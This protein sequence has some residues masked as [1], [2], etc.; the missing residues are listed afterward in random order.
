[1]QKTK[2][3]RSKS[4]TFL[5]RV[6]HRVIKRR[7]SKQVPWYL[8]ATCVGNRHKIYAT[9]NLPHVA[10]NTTK[11]LPNVV[12][13]ATEICFQKRV[14]TIVEVPILA[15]YSIT[16]KLQ[17]SGGPSIGVNIL[18]EREE[19][20]IAQDVDGLQPIEIAVVLDI[21]YYVTDEFGLS[22]KHSYSVISVR[23]FPIQAGATGIGRAGWYNRLFTAGIRYRLRD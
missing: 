3:A 16:D 6:I 8:T 12:K 21:T 1:M 14:K 18:G 4:T 7:G 20:G 11:I 19:N 22:L 5:S 23:D 17:F 15:M 2:S 9:K 13:N 10:E